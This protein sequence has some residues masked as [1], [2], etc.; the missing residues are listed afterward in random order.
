MPMRTWS[1][2]RETNCPLSRTRRAL[3]PALAADAV[4]LPSKLEQSMTRG[5]RRASRARRFGRFFHMWVILPS[6]IRAIGAANIGAGPPNAEPN[7]LGL[8]RSSVSRT[9]LLAFRSVAR[10]AVVPAASGSSHF[11][12]AFCKRN[13]MSTSAPLR[14]ETVLG[15]LLPHGCCT[16]VSGGRSGGCGVEMVDDVAS[17]APSPI[18]CALAGSESANIT[19]RTNPGRAGLKLLKTPL[20]TIPPSLGLR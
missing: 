14:P 15:N 1:D 20:C 17:A 3:G 9:S 4:R 19:A 8:R 12:S 10:S 5:R 2:R 6:A 13:G 11:A 18:C 7:R 16:E